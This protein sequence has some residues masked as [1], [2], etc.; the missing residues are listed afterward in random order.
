M[1]VS[2]HCDEIE[3][4]AGCPNLWKKG[5]QK[6]IPSFNPELL[7]KILNAVLRESGPLRVDV[8]LSP[9]SNPADLVRAGKTLA[10]IKGL[11][12]VVVCNTFPNASS[13]ASDLVGLG[14]APLRFI[15]L[16][17]VLQMRSLLPK[18]IT[19]TAVGGVSLQ[20]HINE[21]RRAGAYD[22]QIGSFYIS[23]GPSVFS[24][25]Q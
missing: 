17:Q 12:G 16:G 4:N 21:Y 3:V 13:G 14:G 7:K 8:K 20:S 11:S 19:I 23:H 22:V 18:R 10:H 24:R 15:T 9:F 25:L 5:K 2:V 6:E 1:L